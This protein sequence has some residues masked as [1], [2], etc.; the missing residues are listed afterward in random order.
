MLLG[1]SRNIYIRLVEPNSD[2]VKNAIEEDSNASNHLFIM[3]QFISL[4]IS[5][6]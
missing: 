4:E 3:V 1:W 2:I 6:N 5:W